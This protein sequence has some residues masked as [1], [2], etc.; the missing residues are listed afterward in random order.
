M[1]GFAIKLDEN[2]GASHQRLLGAAG[3]DV[4]RV[5]EEGLGGAGDHHVWEIVQTADRFFITMDLDFSDVRRFRPGT[6]AGILIVRAREPGPL[7]AQ[8]ILQRVIA[9]HHLRDLSR[10]LVVADERRTRVRRPGEQP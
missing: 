6:H 10:C 3:Y 2:L 4:D 7:A 8:A 5:I 1:N 9:E